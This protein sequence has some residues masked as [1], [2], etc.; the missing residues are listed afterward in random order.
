MI[1]TFARALAGLVL[2]AV[3]TSFVTADDN[4]EELIKRFKDP[5]KAIRDQATLA[6]E[7]VGKSA[8][9]RLIEVLKDSNKTVRFHAV[10]A[11]GLIAADAE[12]A[13][14][15]LLANLQRQA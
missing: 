9:P 4:V 5:D 14:S 15:P 12:P 7:K 11:L 2:F 8:V 3:M 13:V 10:Y 6:F 1:R